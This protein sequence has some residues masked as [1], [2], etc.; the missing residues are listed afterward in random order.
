MNFDA[1]EKAESFNP[2]GANYTTNSC[3]W[4]LNPYGVPREVPVLSDGA[5]F[6][7]YDSPWGNFDDHYPQLTDEEPGAYRELKEHAHGYSSGN[8]W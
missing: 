8:W 5:L 7:P 4:L 1:E 2:R 6:N 3:L